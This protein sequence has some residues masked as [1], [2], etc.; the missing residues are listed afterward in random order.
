MDKEYSGRMFWEKYSQQEIP[1]I[2]QEYE[3]GDRKC[4]NMTESY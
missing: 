4:C 2:F 1:A 3:K